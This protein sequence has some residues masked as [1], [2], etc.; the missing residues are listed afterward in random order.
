MHW[1][2]VTKLGEGISTLPID[3]LLTYFAYNSAELLF[4]LCIK[5]V[6]ED[7][8]RYQWTKYLFL[9]NLCCIPHTW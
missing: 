7:Q 6:S 9:T 4:N 8:M 3:K 1:K 5:S 2:F